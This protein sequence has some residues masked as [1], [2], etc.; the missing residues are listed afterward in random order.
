MFHDCSV[1]HPWNGKTA[2]HRARE[3][4]EI[5]LNELDRDNIRLVRRV[6]TASD[7]EVVDGRRV[8]D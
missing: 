1:R 4:F 5:L 6:W 3:E 8:W 7:W 2:E